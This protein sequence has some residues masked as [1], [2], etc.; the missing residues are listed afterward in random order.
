MPSCAFNGLTVVKKSYSSFFSEVTAISERILLA[1]YFLDV[2][3]F[4]LTIIGS[5]SSPELES[6]SD[7]FLGQMRVV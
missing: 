2:L 6:E 7:F 5:S 4:F 1:L 3:D